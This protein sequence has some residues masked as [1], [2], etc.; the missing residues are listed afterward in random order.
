[1]TEEQSKKILKAF[2][3]DLAK[4]ETLKKMM[5]SA[6]KNVYSD[7]L[8]GFIEN[9]IKG[10]VM[11]EES[12]KAYIIPKKYLDV[13]WLELDGVIY[14]MDAIYDLVRQDLYDLCHFKDRD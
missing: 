7:N 4:E 1:M 5:K 12:L 11:D 13:S 9:S 6:R 2:V 8:A 14:D 3:D 10:V